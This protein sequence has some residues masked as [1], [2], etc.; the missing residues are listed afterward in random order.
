MLSVVSPTTENMSSI[1]VQEKAQVGAGEHELQGRRA[2]IAR[3]AGR[4]TR[5]TTAST[6]DITTV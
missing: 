1:K 4:R 5:A 2:E 3:L 6:G